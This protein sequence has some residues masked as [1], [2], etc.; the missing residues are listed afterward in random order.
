[1]GIVHFEDLPLSDILSVLDLHWNVT[2][3]FD[4]SYLEFGLDEDGN[5]FTRRK[6]GDP[7]YS[8]SDWPERGWTN[9]YR[10]AHTVACDLALEM[11]N[12]GFLVPGMVI[13]AEIV[14]GSQ[15]NTIPYNQHHGCTGT[16]IVTTWPGKIP[17]ELSSFL[18]S[19]LIR[20][21]G[22]I[23][24]SPDGVRINRE[25]TN[26][27][28]R[29]WM[30]NAVHPL[31]IA[32]KLNKPAAKFRRFIDEF[33]VQPSIIPNMSVADCLDAKLNTRPHQIS[34][35]DWSKV[36]SLL[37]LEREHLRKKLRAELLKFKDVVQQSLVNGISSELG[38]GSY[39]EGIV[40]RTEQGILFKVT[41]RREF[42]RANTFSHIVK[43]WLVGGRR[44]ARPCF[45]S[46][47]KDWTLEKR[48]ERLEVLRRRFMRHY[49]KLNRRF[50]IAGW[51][52][53]MSIS[54]ADKELYNRTLMLFADVRERIQN[55]R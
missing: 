20:F 34:S 31:Y 27:V 22:E 18:R 26:Q 8:L 25:T 5:F 46:R 40:V 1:M 44:P 54:Y 14:H 55:G 29:A 17:S 23:F 9:S 11:S 30:A 52:T 7:C 41:A 24:S 39:K 49:P 4:G 37:K 12:H 45:L 19:F 6:G 50:K 28:W 36:K 13:G 10:L 2:E 15:P 43:Y 32:S 3:K 48:L 47:T 53:Y 33:L 38:P 16:L 21:T 35:S 42:T 51:H